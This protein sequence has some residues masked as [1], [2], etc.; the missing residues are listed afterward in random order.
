MGHQCKLLL[1]LRRERGAYD[2]M[3]PMLSH[4]NY[5]YEQNLLLTL[6]QRMCRQQYVIYVWSIIVIVTSA[7]P[8]LHEGAGTAPAQWP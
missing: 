2:R 4:I 3:I 1:W 5:I 6:Y 8:L 7:L